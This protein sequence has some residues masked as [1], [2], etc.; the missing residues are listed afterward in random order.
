MIWYVKFYYF[1]L[2]KY[3]LGQLLFNQNYYVIF[4]TK[5]T[6]FIIIIQISYFFNFS[7]YKIPNKIKTSIK[8]QSNNNYLVIIKKK[9]I[10]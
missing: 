10:I 4:K 9:K 2:Y 7:P 5:K 3:T 8:F 1:F 6:K